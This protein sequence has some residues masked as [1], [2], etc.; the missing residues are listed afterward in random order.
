MTDYDKFVT[1]LHQASL[2]FS[3]STDTA[4]PVLLRVLVWEKED[5]PGPDVVVLFDTKTGVLLNMGPVK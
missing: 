1:M 2:R 5:N 4:N 3:S